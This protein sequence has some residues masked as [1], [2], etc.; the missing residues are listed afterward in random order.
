MRREIDIAA[1]RG[2]LR[3][4]RHLAEIEELFQLAGL[5]MQPIEIPDHDR[6]QEAAPQIVQHPPVRGPHLA[7]VGAHIVIDV[8]LLHLPALSRHQALA[9]LH[10]AADAQMIPVSVRRDPSVDSSTNHSSN[11][12]AHSDVR[13]C[14]HLRSVEDGEELP[15]FGNALQLVPTAILVLQGERRR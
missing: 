10:L 4:A 7:A 6:V 1:D 5:P 2:Q 12:H 3:H 11:I 8:A 15:G 9:V 13:A 14:S